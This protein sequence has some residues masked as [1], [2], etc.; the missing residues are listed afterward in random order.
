MCA[1]LFKVGRTPL[2]PY[3]TDST[4][5]DGSYLEMLRVSA[6]TFP[7]SVYEPP[8]ESAAGETFSPAICSALKA[9]IMPSTVP[10]KPVSGASWLMTSMGRSSA[11]VSSMRS[12]A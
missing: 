3:S 9:V 6:T 5:F 8:P 1:Q 12:L 2:C 7:P 10:S 4:V 11:R